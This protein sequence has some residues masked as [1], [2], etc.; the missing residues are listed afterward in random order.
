MWGIRGG[1]DDDEVMGYGEEGWEIEES[2]AGGGG[3]A[4]HLLADRREEEEGAVVRAGEEGLGDRRG[5]GDSPEDC[6]DRFAPHSNQSICAAAASKGRLP[7][8]PP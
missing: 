3:A 7:S 4:G 1:G 2:D 8:L 5:E 6:C